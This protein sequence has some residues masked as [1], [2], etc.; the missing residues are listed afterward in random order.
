MNTNGPALIVP[1]K[2]PAPAPAAPES[3]HSVHPPVE[4]ADYWLWLWLALG[5]LLAAAILFLLWK[6][7]WKKVA[8]VPPA[9]IIPP[10]IRARRRLDDALRLIDD[11]KTF[12]IAVSDA[13]RQYLEERFNFRAPER[14]TEEFLYELQSTEL[15]TFEQKQSLGEFLS[16]CDMVKFAR[17]E[18]IIDELQSMHRA[19]VRLVSETEPTLADAQNESRSLP[20]S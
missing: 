5:A 1:V 7:W 11:P 9:P 2:P 13:L 15:L 20:A 4:I 18:P 17:Y 6:Y 10:H 16:Q 12:T 14:T 3:L 8:A 19:A